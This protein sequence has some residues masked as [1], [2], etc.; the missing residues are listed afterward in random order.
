MHESAFER[1]QE[2]TCD[3]ELGKIG[4]APL[5]D[6]QLV[7]NGEILALVPAWHCVRHVHVSDGHALCME[8]KVERKNQGRSRKT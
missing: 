4:N 3:R 8:T 2:V 6:S 1:P 5:E 7:A